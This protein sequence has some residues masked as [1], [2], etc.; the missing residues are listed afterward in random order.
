MGRPHGKYKNNSFQM[1]VG[2]AGYEAIRRVRKGGIILWRRE[3]YQSDKL[4][5]YVGQDIFLWDYFGG[6]DV[7]EGGWNYMNKPITWGN[8]ICESLEAN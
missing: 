4:L 1:Q 2:D 7:H 5:E 6:I 8:I 3:R